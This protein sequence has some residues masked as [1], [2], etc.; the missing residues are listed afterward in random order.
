MS[1]HD[2][3]PFLWFKDKA[4]QAAQ[5]YVAIF[6]DSRI[7]GKTYFN[8]GGHGTVGTV[9]TVAFTLDGRPFV[10]INGGPAFTITPAVSFVVHCATQAEIDHYWEHLGEGG[11]PI[12]CGWITDQFGVTWQVIPSELIKMLTT[13]SKEQVERM[14][15]AI[16]PMKKI[17]LATLR[18]AF[19][20][21]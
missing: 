5:F 1:K 15:N 20:G 19:D 2:L 3:T 13:G 10:A 4:E 12:Q 18:R 9:M 11:A 8:E 21:R 16:N 14:M 6:P 7:D 17:D